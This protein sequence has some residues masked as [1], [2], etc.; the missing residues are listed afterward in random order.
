M[1]AGEVTL[2]SELRRGV[3]AFNLAVGAVLGAAAGVAVYAL[4]GAGA[5]AVAVALGVFGFTTGLH[6]AAHAYYGWRF[7]RGIRASREGDH[8][9]AVALL[10]AVARRGMDHYDEAGAAR[11]ALAAS[12]TAVDQGD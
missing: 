8:A 7:E 10:G 5:L 11:R 3:N 12:Q 9:R 1:R 6:T 2:R 4:F